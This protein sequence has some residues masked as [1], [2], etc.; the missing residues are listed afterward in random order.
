[1]LIALGM[2]SGYI[3]LYSGQILLFLFFIIS[4]IS[5]SLDRNLQKTTKITDFHYTKLYK[6]PIVQPDRT[7]GVYSVTN[8][9]AACHTSFPGFSWQC[10]SGI[11]VLY[12]EAPDM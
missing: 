8:S 12:F 10:I 9:L 4:V 7:E 3:H 2:F 1:M 11:T 6:S 5:K